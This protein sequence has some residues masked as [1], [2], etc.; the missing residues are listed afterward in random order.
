MYTAEVLAIMTSR[1]DPNSRDVMATLASS[2]RKIVVGATVG[3]RPVPGLVPPPEVLRRLPDIMRNFRRLHS[4]GARIVAGT[5]AGIA[6]TKPPDSVRYAVPQLLELGMST[7]AALQ[8]I[9]SQSADVC[10]LGDPVQDVTALHRIR[11]VYR[12]G[13]LVAP[14]DVS[15]GT[16]STRYGH[17]HKTGR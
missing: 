15:A 13:V 3:F 9:T 2:R 17:A 7:G 16:C 12:G 11:A 4:L 8:T 5:D 10:G 6:P 14:V 1:G